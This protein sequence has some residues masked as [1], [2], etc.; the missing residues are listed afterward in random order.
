MEPPLGICKGREGVG[1]GVLVLSAGLEGAGIEIRVGVDCGRRIVGAGA[2]A[3][4]AVK[5]RERSKKVF[6]R[7]MRMSEP[8]HTHSSRFIR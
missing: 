5:K 8:G 2:I 3:S 7:R 6:V 4:Q 1:N